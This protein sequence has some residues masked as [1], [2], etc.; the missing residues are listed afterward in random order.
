MKRTLRMLAA[1]LIAAATLTGGALPAEQP[2]PVLD[3]KA[4]VEGGAYFPGDTIRIQ[5]AQQGKQGVSF[6]LRDANTFRL[7]KLEWKKLD[8]RAEARVYYVTI[9]EDTPQGYYTFKAGSNPLVLVIAGKEVKGDKWIGATKTIEKHFTI[10][11][12]H[13]L[14]S[15]TVFTPNTRQV[16]LAGEEIEFV[17]AIKSTKAREAALSC[18]LAETGGEFKMALVSE[19]VAARLGT[20]TLA[21]VIPE[22]VTC[23]LKPGRYVIESRFGD[24]TGNAVEIEIVSAERK[25]HY[26]V[27]YDVVQ[28]KGFCFIPYSTYTSTLGRRSRLTRDGEP[29]PDYV[30]GIRH[31]LAGAGFNMAKVHSGAY[32]ALDP[33]PHLLPKRSKEVDPLL[34]PSEE[35]LRIP[36]FWNAYL[37]E[38]LRAKVG[39]VVQTHQGNIAV[40]IPEYIGRQARH[41]TLYAQGMRRYPSFF[42]VLAGS[43]DEALTLGPGWCKDPFGKTPMDYKQDGIANQVRSNDTFLACENLWETFRNE[44]GFKFDN[45]LRWG[46]LNLIYDEHAGVWSNRDLVLKWARFVQS[47]RSR[48]QRR[49][50]NTIARTGANIIMSGGRTHGIQG[51]GNLYRPLCKGKWTMAEPEHTAEGLDVIWLLQYGYDWGNGP[52]TLGIM[53]DFYQTQR[54]RGIPLWKASWGSGL[55]AKVDLGCLARDAIEIVGH[56][57]VAGCAMEDNDPNGSDGLMQNTY[58][59][60]AHQEWGRRERIKL[61]TDILTR[62]GD[63]FLGLEPVKDVA[64]L[65]SMTQGALG[66]KIKDIYGVMLWQLAEMCLFS[67][68]PAKFVCE[69][70]IRAGRLGDYKVLLV[71]GARHEFPK[72]IAAGLQDFIKAGGIVLVDD[73]STIA[74]PGAKKM[75]MAVNDLARWMYQNN[76]NEAWSHVYTE[77]LNWNWHRDQALPKVPRFKKKMCEF[78]PVFADCS[79][80]QILLSRLTHGECTYLFATN[81][82]NLPYKSARDMPRPLGAFD[83][84]WVRPVREEISVPQGD[85]VIYDLLTQ[86]EVVTRTQEGRRSFAAD[87]SAIEA[88]IY[89]ILPER[90]G[91]VELAT[92]S[93]VR[94]GMSLPIE[95]KVLGASGRPLNGLVPVE[96]AVTDEKGRIN[97]HVFRAVSAG[98]HR[99]RFAV[100]LNAGATSYTITVTDLLSRQVATRKVKVKGAVKPG[101]GAE[102]L[103]DCAVFDPQ[104]VRKFLGT[105]KDIHIALSREQWK[106]PAK[107]AL[108]H[109]LAALLRSH[110]VS[111]TLSDADDLTIGTNRKVMFRGGCM[112]PPVPMV[113]KDVILM[114]SLEENTLID[115]LHQ[116]DILPRRLSESYP[117]LGRCVVEFGFC[118]FSGEHDALCLLAGDAAGLEVGIAEVAKLLSADSVPLRDRFAESREKA[119]LALLPADLKRSWRRAGRDM[120]QEFAGPPLAG[121]KLRTKGTTHSRADEFHFERKIG[122]PIWSISLSED[123][124]TLAVGTDSQFENL[125]LL[126]TDSGEIKMR[127]DTPGRWIHRAAVSNKAGRLFASVA[128]TGQIVAYDS[129]E[130]KL[131]ERAAGIP[132][133]G[134]PAAHSAKTPPDPAYFYLDPSGQRAFFNEKA[135]AIV[136]RDLKTGKSLWQWQYNSTKEKAPITYPTVF[137]ISP[138]AKFLAVATRQVTREDFTYRGGGEGTRYNPE[139]TLLTVQVLEAGTG[140]VVAS[141]NKDKVHEERLAIAPGG[142]HL[143][144]AGER[145]TDLLDLTGKRLDRMDAGQ[146]GSEHF[147]GRFSADGNKLVCWPQQHHRGFRRE[148]ASRKLI[149][150]DIPAKSTR[151]L[152]GDESVADAAWMPGDSRIVCSRWDGYVCVMDAAGNAIWKRFVGSGARVIAGADGSVFA[153]AA[154]GWLY[155]FDSTGKKLWEK[156]L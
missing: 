91:R 22:R 46:Q 38:L 1:F 134:F 94:K 113:L 51:E 23:A 148:L 76:Y 19:N 124:S 53:P 59:G 31:K 21:Y 142:K 112:L 55:I 70:D 71:V 105:G 130:K 17:A 145:F 121:G 24:V 40:G 114:G 78:L 154:N 14:G 69:T 54:E 155:R 139:N 143:L 65:A 13:P 86:K 102:K 118:A 68:Y 48:V 83:Q 89:C 29:L 25:T 11:L 110:G 90:I 126:D 58:D 16:Y 2:P 117:G 67:R 95:V 7:S 99:E 141:F 60:W 36:P 39:L 115:A 64:I 151:T 127:T 41:F 119:R 81:Y 80:N 72:D 153:G 111:C 63:V 147:I 20:T 138:D 122:V 28:R 18:S 150:K 84:L 120:P 131:W 128:S 140:K 137:A 77:M 43:Q 129:S 8:A 104:A 123:G 144:L 15:L 133:Q 35:A 57:A 136:C 132:P 49:W 4:T 61:V 97:H 34:V 74:I 66:P 37:Q 125:F 88:R 12:T 101:S 107:L 27:L 152:V 32:P 10:A 98:G 56:G 82:N 103:P 108:A 109:R 106:R 30:R 116:T 73:T 45:P 92:V 50:H 62:Y 5:V 85:D 93:S 44:T 79:N 9:P 33:S 47:L 87:F 75:G 52:F 146:R 42:G 156:K 100:P 26:P 149:I 135:G 3:A 6:A 96:I